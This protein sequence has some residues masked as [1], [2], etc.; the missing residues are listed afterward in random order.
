MLAEKRRRKMNIRITT[1]AQF[2]RTAAI[3]A[4]QAI[5]RKPESVLGFATGA[6]TAPVHAALAELILLAGADVSRI[7]TANVDEY[8]GVPSDH[9]GTC[10]SR[11]WRQLFAPIRLEKTQVHCFDGMAADLDLECARL[12]ELVAQ[13]GGIDL[14][15][16]GI[17][18]DGH[19]GFNLPGTPF[20]RGAHWFPFSAE[21]RTTP[22]RLELF[23]TAAQTPPRA[24]T[25]GIC[26]IMRCKKIVVVANTENKAEILRKMVRGPVTEAVPASVLQLH[27]D[28]TLIVTECAAAKL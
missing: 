25:L 16:L 24:I 2:A 11:M 28:V 1:Q 9:P 23:G 13:L 22:Y 4:V 20:G 14:Q 7:Q 12:P 15:Y 3:P 21:Q 27:P 18:A 10:A 26:D 6:T 8:G 5:L 17:G 19:L